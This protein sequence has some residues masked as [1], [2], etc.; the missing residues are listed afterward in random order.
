VDLILQFESFTQLVVFILEITQ[1]IYNC[2]AP[3]SGFNWRNGMY[4]L[5]GFISIDDRFLKQNGGNAEELWIV[6]R[7]LLFFMVVVMSLRL[8][9]SH[10]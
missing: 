5:Y 10:L 3:S 1:I 4:R 7:L 2:V 9:N 8:E 6:E